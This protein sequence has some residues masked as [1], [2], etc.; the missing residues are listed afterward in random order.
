MRQTEMDRFTWDCSEFY[1]SVYMR[2]KRLS[3]NDFIGECGS[4]S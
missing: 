1:L 4:G 3:S 2:E